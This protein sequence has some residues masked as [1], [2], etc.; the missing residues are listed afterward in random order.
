LKA[1]GNVKASDKVIISGR[2][3][4]SGK[5]FWLSE[6][7]QNKKTSGGPASRKWAKKKRGE[8]VFFD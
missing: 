7:R 5:L 1:G 8:G 4:S 6:G 2:K 3:I